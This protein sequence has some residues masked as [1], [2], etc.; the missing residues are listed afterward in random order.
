MNESARMEASGEEFPW[1]TQEYA[2][3][4]SGSV[5]VCARDTVQDRGTNAVM[6]IC[7]KSFLGEK[8]PD[9]GEKEEE[10]ETEEEQS[11]RYRNYLFYLFLFTIYRLTPN[12]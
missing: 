3:R 7:R 4:C 9:E 8:S 12:S 2:D 5:E 10:E 11:T 6:F 1:Y